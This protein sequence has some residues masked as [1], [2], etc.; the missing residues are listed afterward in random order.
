MP[1]AALHVLLISLHTSPLEQPG[2]G[3]AGGM[4]V[5][6]RH[7]AEGLVA[8]GHTVDMAVLD[9]SPAAP[10]APGLRT[11]IVGPGLRLL[12]VTLPGAAGADKEDL[13]RFVDCFAAVLGSVDRRP[14]VVHAHYWLSGAAGRQVAEAWGVPLVLSLHTTARAKNLRAARGEGSE[15]EARAAA[16]T[17]LIARADLTV[18]NTDTEATQMVELYD[19]DPER[20]A[21]V[22]PG[23]DLRV[24]HPPH[25]PA[26]RP[27]G[28]ADGQPGPG[29]PGRPLRLL[30][31][32]R[33]QALKGPQVLV[34]A[35][36]LL[37][38]LAPGLAVELEIAGVGAPGFAARLRERV[39]S[40]GLGGAVSFAPALPAPELAER[41][42]RADL[43]AVPSSS[44]TFGLVAL[45][46]QACGTPVLATD[47]DG[48]RVAVLDG[49]TGRLVADRSPAAWARA[50]AD[51]AREPGALRRAGGA[52]AYR[53]RA[54]SWERTAQIT[55]GLYARAGIRDGSR[56]S[57]NTLER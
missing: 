36:A 56:V 55:A 14:D 5:Y 15:P 18:V 50:V 19:A 52:A 20:L 1:D 10:A 4:N 7:L 46:A 11:R 47:V 48:L 24:F 6:V 8:A 31:A 21:V 29:T 2:S 35:L 3:D 41:M 27:G 22:A 16:E 37:P 33:L 12:T 28:P 25:G 43:V 54:Y 40:L 42:R 32:G 44:E 23:V 39:R 49:V 34:E 51:L 26:D 53:A 9:R 13:P 57:L 17:E 38:G 30:F 45:E